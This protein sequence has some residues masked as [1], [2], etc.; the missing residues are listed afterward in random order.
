MLRKAIG[1][2]DRDLMKTMEEE[3][4]SGCTSRGQTVEKSEK[5]WE[6]IVKFADYAFNK[7]HSYAY[8]LI[9]YWTMYLKLNHPKEFAVSLLSLDMKDTSKLRSHFFAFK[10]EI[11]F[12]PPY[13]NMAKEGFKLSD[14]GVMMG[15]GSIKGM[16][17]SSIS[18]EN[19]Q[20]YKNIPDI[21][22]KN[23]LD[24]TQLTTLI[25]SGAFDQIETDK[26]VLLGNLERLLKFGKE[27]KTSDIF[28]IFDPAEIFNLDRS[29]K[30]KLPI[31][32]YMEK[33]CYGFNIYHGFIG[34]NKWLIDSL[35]S[36][37]VIGTITEIKRTKTKA[38]QQDMA[39]LT[40]ETAKG[41]M[42]A[43][44]FPNIY[45]KFSIQLAKEETYAFRGELKYGK[46]MEGDEEAS[47]IVSDMLIESGILINEIRLER[48]RKITQGQFNAILD[49]CFVSKGITTIRVFEIQNDG[50]IHFLFKHEQSITYNETIH[51]LLLDNGFEI[52]IK[53]F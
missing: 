20:P 15:F 39:I 12:E 35:E 16:G 45:D 11:L 46:N 41:N 7:S 47:L 31:E 18:I 53:V 4:I 10:D 6:Q 28:N 44:L 24:K 21:V 40:I 23:N 22:V 29:R 5:L 37:S 51:K 43:V 25:Y 8:T 38:K 9:S 33:L 42:K 36:D 17:N 52:S 2:K 13:I 34:K 50:D 48:D 19:N 1:K 30:A 14:N 27:N 32:G 49:N 3:F 26:S